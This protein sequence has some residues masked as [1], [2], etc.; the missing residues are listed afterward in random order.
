MGT[1]LNPDGDRIKSMRIQRGWTQEQLA[2]IAGISPRTIQRAEKANNASFET[3]RAIAGAFETDFERLLKSDPVPEPAPGEPMPPAG[4]EPALI[5][6]IADPR[7]APPPGSSLR[8]AWP[9]YAVA[10][11]A[12]AAGWIGGMHL[13][14]RGGEPAAPRAAVSSPKEPA[15]LRIPAREAS[16]APVA[17][18]PEAVVPAPGAPRV[19]V[20]SAAPARQA[21]IRRVPAE[22]HGIRGTAQAPAAAPDRG[23]AGG[24]VLY[25][26]SAVPELS[27]V[28]RDLLSAYAIPQ[29]AAAPAVDAE[30]EDQDS[31]A[32]RQALG[33]AAKRTGSFMSR[34]GTSLKRVF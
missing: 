9:V 8:R 13:G 25:A 19:G 12:L 14:T 29:A 15:P 7:P 31:G 11:A 20:G 2:E 24:P 6:V 10:L 17:K 27:P 22:K 5:P 28:S 33:E 21:E 3:V 23:G 26:S 18:L 34:V 32:V 1:S 4:G 16:A 30:A